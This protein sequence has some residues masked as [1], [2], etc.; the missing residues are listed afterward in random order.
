MKSGDGIVA[1]GASRDLVFSANPGGV[2][3][4]SPWRESWENCEIDQAP[5]RGE[6]TFF[7]PLRGLFRLLTSPTACAVGYSLSP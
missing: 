5:V 4:S 6:R 7:R 2:K 3:E 1:F